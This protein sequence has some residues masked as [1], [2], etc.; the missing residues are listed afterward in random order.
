M[1][2]AKPTQDT[3]DFSS[4]GLD[5]KLVASL[6]ELGYEEPTPVQAQTIPPLLAGRD[7]I[8][9][10]ATGTGKT[11][12]FGLPMLQRV[13][14]MGPKRPKPSG[15]IL[16]PTRELAMQVAE[17]MYRYGRGLNISA[18]PIYGGH[19]FSQQQQALKRGIDIV[20]ATPGRALD[21]I[22]RGTLDLGGVSILTLDEADEMLDMGFADDL[23]AILTEIPEERQTIFFSATLPPR[24][25]GMTKRHLR[26][27]LR[28]EIGRESVDKGATPKVRQTAYVIPRARKL[29]ALSRILDL[30]NPDSALIFCRTRTE[31]DLLTERLAAHGYRSQA[32]HGG[33]SQ[34]QRTRVIKKLRDGAIDLVVATD[35]AARGLDIEQ[36]SHV[37]NYDVPATPDAY[38]HRVGRVG[39]AGREGVA[40]TLADPR[41]SRLLKQFERQINSK[42]QIEQVPTIADL[43]ARRLEVTRGAIEEALLEG[44]LDPY[45][46]VVES[47]SQEHDLLDIAIAAVKVAQDATDGEREEDG[48]SVEDFA[49]TPQAPSGGRKGAARGDRRGGP[50]ANMARIYIGAGRHGGIRAGD[51][52]GAI[53]GESGISGKVIGG[54][55]IGD[56]FS[57]VELPEEVVE[58]VLRA[59]SR[60]TIK[61]KKVK[62]RR[63]VEQ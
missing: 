14:E 35:V 13:A 42:I 33:I 60:A 28:I 59:M 53:A 29:T 9:Q 50:S 38:V 62:T 1:P 4:L 20:V 11:A 16:V 26:D 61:G 39:R 52:V 23:E 24:I 31:V 27:P 44:D 10:A 54:I 5:E 25:A 32:M 6:T 22:R 34:D 18:M 56:H 55:D 57:I 63:F 19:S 21:H 36:L 37:I 46:V 15:L 2:N 7:L 51:L 30:E 3:S 17:A 58:D 48:E 41:E 47:L 40:I 12:A 43:R 45:R 49:V 8:G